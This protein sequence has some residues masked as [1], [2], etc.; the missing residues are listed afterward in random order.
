MRRRVPASAL[1]LL[2]FAAIY[3]IW[4]S[5]FFA[6]R[7]AIETIPPIP[8]AGVR[9]LAA[10]ALLFP[11][12]YLSGDRRGDRVTPVHWRSALIIGTLLPAA[13][14]GG[15][16]FAEQHVASGVT[17]LMM[18]SI[19][20]WMAIFA[21]LGRVQR[22]GGV[23]IASLVAGFAGV[24]LLLGPG[25][26]VPSSPLWLCV[27]LIPPICWSAGSIYARGAPKPGRALLGSA[28]QLLCGGAVLCLVAVPLGE[29]GRVRFAAISPLS[30]GALA[31]LAVAGSLVA[32]SAYV[33]L[34][35][36]VSPRAVSSY[37]YV[38]T[39]VALLLGG[40][41]LGERITPLT[42]GAAALICV[43]VAS[44]LASAG[45][46]GRSAAEE[47]TAAAAEMASA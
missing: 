23:G 20:L 14:T 34:L 35:R 46:P 24:G 16:S 31:Y 11:I 29:W 21:H 19:P 37:A 36:S 17:A 18:A 26:A 27:T 5:T 38:N 43:A 28:M 22:L 30:A 42:L 40:I 1:V 2:S 47:E 32:Y 3:L 25:A 45:R 39:L 6:I 7:L 10:G 9:F 12:A 33:F 15:I 41:L 8:M 4:G 44:L 13:G